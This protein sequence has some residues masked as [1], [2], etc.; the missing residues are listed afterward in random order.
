[1]ELKD[2]W[3]YKLNRTKLIHEFHTANSSTPTIKHAHTEEQGGSTTAVLGLTGTDR[4][5]L[6]QSSTFLSRGKPA[7]HENCLT[8]CATNS[9]TGKIFIQILYQYLICRSHFDSHQCGSHSHSQWRFPLSLTL[10]ASDLKF[11]SSQGRSH[12]DTSPGKSHF[13]S[14]QHRSHFDSNQHRSHFDS[15]QHRSHFDSSQHRSQFDNS[16]HRS[17]FDSSEEDTHQNNTVA[18]VVT[19]IWLA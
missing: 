9:I 2:W 10:T 1:M 17:H 8:V 13:D 3:L 16:Q 18:T 11:D 19:S 14:S 12:F 4:W 6:N 7:N 5:R 15:S